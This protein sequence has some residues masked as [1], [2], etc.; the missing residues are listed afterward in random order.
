MD[1]Q[2]QEAQ[3]SPF[4]LN[5]KKTSPSHIIIKPSKVKNRILKAAKGK[6]H[7]F[8]R[9]PHKPTSLFLKRNLAGKSR[10]IYSKCWGNM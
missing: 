3:R 2:V 8:Q 6:G 9:N 10:M 4:R 7:L 1:V 5:S